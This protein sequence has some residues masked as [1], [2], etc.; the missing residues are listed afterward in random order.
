MTDDLRH[1]IAQALADH[2]QACLGLGADRYPAEKWLCCAD[3]VIAVLDEAF[4][5]PQ[6]IEPA[7]PITPQ[8]AEAW[9]RAWDDVMGRGGEPPC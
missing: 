4:P 9:Q 3:A 2:E 7:D 1:R 8:Q 6:F 5:P